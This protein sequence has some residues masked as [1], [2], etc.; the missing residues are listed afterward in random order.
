MQV[1]ARR[2]ALAVCQG[3][4]SF[5]CAECGGED[6]ICR[7]CEPPPRSAN[8]SR[9]GHPSS[10]RARKQ[11]AAA[12]AEN[13]PTPTRA[14]SHGDCV[15]RGLRISVPSTDVVGPAGA[16]GGARQVAVVA[17]PSAGATATGPA[18]LVVV[19]PSV[20]EIRSG[21]S[22]RRESGIFAA[23]GL[24]PVMTLVSSLGRGRRKTMATVSCRVCPT[25]PVVSAI[26]RGT[27][28]GV[29]P[30]LR[31]VFVDAPSQTEE[32]SRV[33][34]AE[35]TPPTSAVRAK[36]ATVAVRMQGEPQSSI[37]S[38]SQTGLEWFPLP[39]TPTLY[40]LPRLSRHASTHLFPRAHTSTQTDS[41]RR[42][43]DCDRYKARV[44]CAECGNSS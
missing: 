43:A 8:S 21:S 39:P 37:E 28:I 36:L 19:G 13:A 10:G 25:A 6:I 9:M 20:A 41:D 44:A 31:T 11:E 17:P 7:A 29:D 4:A 30:V 27:V 3:E 12:A 18:S 23:G 35:L 16:D 1:T 24:T 38:S 32:W 42:H 22:S 5:E 40:V 26:T 15:G 2:R 34:S 14:S 33:S